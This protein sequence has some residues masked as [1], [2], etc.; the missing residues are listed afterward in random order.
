MALKGVDIAW[1]RPTIAAIKATGAHFVARYL[2]PDSSKNLTAGEVKDYPANGLSIVVVWES[3]ASRATQGEAAGTA[4]AR[5]AVEQRKALGLPATLPIYFA[6]DEDTSWASVAAYFKGAEQVL[7]L[8]L[9]GVYGGIKVIEGAA[10]AGIHYLWQ[11]VAWSGGK[12]SSHATIRQEGGTVLAGAADVDY[13]ETTDFGQY[14][15]P[16]NVPAKPGGGPKPPVKPTISLV[17]LVKAAQTDPGASQGHVTDKVD[18][19][20]VERALHAEGLLDSKWVDGSYGTLTV[21]AYAQLQHNLGYR[22]AAADG[23]PGHASLSWLGGKHGF[24]VK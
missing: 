5:Q 16:T 11:T 20:L 14:P 2:S 10:S 6:V 8:G 18:V 3:T 22:G 4:D 17:N 12:W 9:V 21:K 13:A 7:G 24:L 15:R 23:I 19:L 1:D